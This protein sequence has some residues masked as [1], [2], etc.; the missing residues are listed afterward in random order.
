MMSLAQSRS[1]NGDSIIFFQHICLMPLMTAGWFPL[2][3]RLTSSDHTS[4]TNDWISPWLSSHPDTVH[5][6]RDDRPFQWLSLPPSLYYYLS[7]FSVRTQSKEWCMV[8][9]PWA[10]VRE[11]PGRKGK[12]PFTPSAFCSLD[13]SW[14]FFHTSCIAHSHSTCKTCSFWL[15]VRT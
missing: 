9:N 15:D 8:T 2:V 13:F 10:T 4:S 5:F 7:S 12:G 3:F 1:I 6:Q 11:A 14:M